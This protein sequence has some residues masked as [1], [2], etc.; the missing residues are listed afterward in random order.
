MSPVGTAEPTV[1]ADRPRA[2]R[3]PRPADDPAAAVGPRYADLEG[4]RGLAALG[5]V[6]YHVVQ[7]SAAQDPGVLAERSGVLFRAYHGMDSLV[8]LFFVLSAFLLALP[9]ARSALRGERSPSGRAFLV[10][11]AARI[12]P[13][14]VVAVS[15]VWAVRNPDLPGDLLDLAEHLTFTQVFDAQRIFWTIGPAWSLAVEVQFYVLLAV[16]GAVVCRVSG[17]VPAAARLPVLAGSVVAVG[18]ASLAWKAVAWYLLEV[19]GD[20]WPTW[21]GLAA[22][23]DVFAL[24]VLL[25]VA[26]AR[27]AQ[28]GRA[29][30]LGLRLAAAAVLVLAVGTRT[31]DQGEHVWFHSLAAVGFTLL[32]ASSVLGPRD[33]WVRGLSTAVPTFLG[34]VSYSLY[35]WHEP[36]LLLADDAGLMPVL[37]GAGTVGVGLAVVV[38]AAVV[39]AWASYHVV[40]RP[41]GHLRVLVD[42]D[43]RSRDYYDG[44]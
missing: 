22:K 20:H 38:P 6:V 15:V 36:L 25:A 26:V 29:G 43:G 13:L 44:T 5:V 24:G 27:G 40:E 11:R 33:G 7:H 31:V 39:V 37:G 2:P 12:V 35:L 18:L 42:R 9:Y 1:A 8:D 30:A 14:Y 21:Y 23:L 3:R 41:A 16:V 4:Y 10:R 19:P 34:V 28:V 17:R 32:L